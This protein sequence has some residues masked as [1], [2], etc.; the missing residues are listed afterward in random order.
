MDAMTAAFL[1]AKG[2][3]AYSHVFGERRNVVCPRSVSLPNFSYLWVSDDG[4][5]VMLLND[6][7]RLHANAVVLDCMAIPAQ[8]GQD[9]GIRRVIVLR[10]PSRNAP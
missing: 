2:Q 4:S 10:Q 1:Q 5:E 3:P 9:V 7:D 8:P 6:G